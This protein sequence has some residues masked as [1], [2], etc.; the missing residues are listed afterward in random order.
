MRLS[1]EVLE[2]CGLCRKPSYLVEVG[3]GDKLCSPQRA[4]SIFFLGFAN[5][6]SLSTASC[7]NQELAWTCLA[8]GD[9]KTGLEAA[10]QV[11][12]TSYGKPSRASELEQGFLCSESL[13]RDDSDTEVGTSSPW[14]SPFS[15]THVQHTQGC[16]VRMPQID[17]RWT[18]G[19]V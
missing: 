2:A 8:Q 13:C 10:A 4:I 17:I 11:V 6:V 5:F 12:G 15:C 3:R 1:H 16:W 18:A 14:E 9:Q 7:L 19:P